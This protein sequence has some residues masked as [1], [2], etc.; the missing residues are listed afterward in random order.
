MS[1]HHRFGGQRRLASARRLYGPGYFWDRRRRMVVV[2]MA[3]ELAH[4]LYVSHVTL[5]TASGTG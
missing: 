5:V 1:M 4:L 3:A 2:S